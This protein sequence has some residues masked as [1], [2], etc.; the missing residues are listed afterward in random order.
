MLVIG[1]ALVSVLIAGWKIHKALGL[2]LKRVKSFPFLGFDATRL[3]ENSASDIESLELDKM[4]VDS[5][6][7]IIGPLVII[8]AMYSLFLTPQT[9][10]YSWL[11]TTL[12]TLVYALGFVL[13][14]PQLFLNYKLK[15][16][17]HLPWR[18]LCLRFVNTFIDD[19][20]AFVI[21]MPMLARLGCFR[22]D[23]VFFVFLYQRYIYEVDGSR[24]FEGSAPGEVEMEKK[25]V[26]EKKNEAKKKKKAE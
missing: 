7:S 16:V 18:V 15:T 8:Y 11:I 26:E 24:Q 4:A 10:W 6:G 20:F 21:R 12:S 1:P 13:M 3:K 23:I 5:L 14:T 19:L 17:A 2:Q 9:G 22:D 25:E